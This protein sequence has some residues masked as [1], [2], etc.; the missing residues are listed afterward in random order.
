M[1]SNVLGRA[2]ISLKESGLTPRRNMFRRAVIAFEDSGLT[3][4][5]NMLRRAS[6]KLFDVQRFPSNR[7]S[8]LQAK[9][10]LTCS[11]AFEES[12]LTRRQKA[13]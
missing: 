12:G 10:V 11:D 2:A 3:R 4:R 9:S 13:F 8:V 1:L 6:K 7:G 5:R